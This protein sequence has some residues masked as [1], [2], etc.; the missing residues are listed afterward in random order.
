MPDTL[1]PRKIWSHQYST[2]RK[3]QINSRNNMAHGRPRLEFEAERRRNTAPL[4]HDRFDEQL[5][6]R[7]WH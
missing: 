6:G 7:N 1:S 2:S 4:A 5:G 3:G